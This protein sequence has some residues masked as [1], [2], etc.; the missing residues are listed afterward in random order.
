MKK[1]TAI[2][3]I[4][5]LALGLFTGC[6]QAE[7][8]GAIKVTDMTNREITLDAPATR[9]VALM[10][11]D[12]EILYAIGAG[13]T[14]VGRGEYC[15]YPTEINDVPAVQSGNETNIEQIIA[16]DPDIIIMSKMG[17]TVEQVEAL[18]NAGIE[19][20]VSD[21]QDIAGVYTAIQLIGQLTDKNENAAKVIGEMKAA[22]DEIKTNAAAK[23]QNKSIYF[24][25]SPLEW[26]LWTTGQNTFMHEIAEMLGLKNIF[27]DVSGWA[28][29]SAEQVIVRNPDYIVTTTMYYGSGPLPEDEIKSRSGWEGISAIVNN[30]V[31]NAISDEM[32][33]PSVRLVNGAKALYNFVY[34]E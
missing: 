25:A 2:I 12:C 14:L 7:K 23:T 6:T 22:F 15:N 21:A 24:E 26:G 5:I 3:L 16:L 33:I 34:G 30:N 9:I 17:Q 27:E 18:S 28:E 19:V 29:V 20:F 32:T 10:P 8:E 31:F 1:I 11:A 13:D 4:L